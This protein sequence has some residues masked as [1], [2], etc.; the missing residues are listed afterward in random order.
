MQ[1]ELPTTPSSNERQSVPDGQSP[2]FGQEIPQ[3]ERGLERGVERQEQR[4]ETAARASE[5]ARQAPMGTPP[6]PTAVQAPP[7]S[8]TQ[9]ADGNPTSA[10]DEDL[11]EKEWVDRAKKIISATQDDPAAREREVAKLQEDYLKKR[12]GKH[13]GAN[14]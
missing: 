2:E 14:E 7:Q 13:L 4:A 8:V 12:Y 6:M 1:P 10:A 9:P 11:I 5:M 3:V